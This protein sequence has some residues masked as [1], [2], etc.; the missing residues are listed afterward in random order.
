MTQKVKNLV[1]IQED[2]CLTP[3]LARW[4]KD[5]ALPQAV[6]QVADAAQI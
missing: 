2:V 3:G 6:A 5:Q 1:S 4:I